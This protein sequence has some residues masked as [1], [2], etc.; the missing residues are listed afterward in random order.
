MTLSDLAL[1]GL[2]VLAGAVAALAGFG[3]GSLLTPA[4]A[5]SLGVQTA[6]VVVSIPHMITTGYRFW[7][8]RRDVNRHVLLTFGVAS[9]I[10]G[11]A[12]AVIAIVPG[13][14]GAGA[15]PWRA[16]DPR[17]APLN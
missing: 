9:A 7:L 4:L 6:V 17:P 12:G 5:I 13:Q 10:G 16:P 11:L 15:G 14:F 1:F 2:A 8:L 3:I